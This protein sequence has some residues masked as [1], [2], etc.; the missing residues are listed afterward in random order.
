MSVSIN[1]A[2]DFRAVLAAPVSKLDSLKHLY[3]NALDA[4]D[5]AELSYCAACRILGDV[6][7]EARQ[8]GL[9]GGNRRPA[10]AEAMRIINRQRKALRRAERA[11]LGV[12]DALAP[13]P[14]VAEAVRAGRS[15]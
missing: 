13:W 14:G 2:A 11:C 5:D 7:R 15:H 8:G 4:L 3:R 9:F 10:R 6:N 12:L 1:A